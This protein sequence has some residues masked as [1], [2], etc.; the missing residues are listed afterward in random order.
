MGLGGGGFGRPV[1]WL[2]GLR[3]VSGWWEEALGREV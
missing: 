3:G 2:R 1:D